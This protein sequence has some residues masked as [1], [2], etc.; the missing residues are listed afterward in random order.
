MNWKNEAIN[1]L[2]CYDAMRQAIVNIPERLAF[3]EKDASRV[4]ISCSEQTPVK[5]GGGRKE[6]V[7]I[8]NIVSRQ[9]LEWR[10]DEAKNWVHI[11]DRGLSALDPEGKLI[12]HRL[13]ICPQR[14]AIDQLCDDLGVEQSSVYR[15]RDKA[16]HTF[17]MALYGVGY[18]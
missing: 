3:L 7:L 13:Y 14:G 2:R 15:K 16:L 11:V 17:T 1:K 6:D 4:R 12:L 9:E 18:M 8:N 5:G 10:L